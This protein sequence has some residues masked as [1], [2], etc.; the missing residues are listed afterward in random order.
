[1]PGNERTCRTPGICEL[2]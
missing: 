2:N 1:M